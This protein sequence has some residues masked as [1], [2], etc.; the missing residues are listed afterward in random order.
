LCGEFRTVKKAFEDPILDGGAKRS[1]LKR[2]ATDPIITVF[3]L[4]LRFDCGHCNVTIW[5]Y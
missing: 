3:N 1:V 5:Y 4:K 2:R